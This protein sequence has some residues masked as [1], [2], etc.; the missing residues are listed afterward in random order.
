MN[1]YEHHLGDY[2]KDTGHLSMLEHG[3]YRLLLD[4]YY[5]TEAGIPADQVHRIARARTKDERQAVDAVLADFFV[6]ENDLWINRRAEEEIAKARVKIS[7]AKENGKKGGR[8]RGKKPGSGNVTD[9]K[10]SGLYMGSEN[11]TQQKAHQAP[12]TKHQTPEVNQE[13]AAALVDIPSAA[14][15]PPSDPITARA[16]ELSI[17]L[18]QRGAALQASDPRVRSWA[19]NGITDAQALTALDTA[20][21]RRQDRSDPKPVNAGLIDAIL[22]D[23]TAGRQ[24]QTDVSNANTAAVAAWLAE[25]E[26]AHA[27]D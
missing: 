20:Q 15:S 24:Q 17:Q 2:A 11:E 3:A 10:P 22:G 6:L 23:I 18:R 4:R 25:Q 7:A 5:G 21:Q 13:E 12:S 26:E 1:Y 27:T 14:A 16:I 19:E 9:E 8:P